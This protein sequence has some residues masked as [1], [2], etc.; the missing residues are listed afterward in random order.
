MVRDQASAATTL[1]RI[2]NEP[3]AFGAIKGKTGILASKANSQDRE[4]ALR[5][6]PALARNLERFLEMRRETEHKHQTE[7]RAARLRV[8]IDIPALSPSAK[9]VL[10]RVRDAIDRNDLSDGLAY[11]LADRMVKDELESFAKAVAER[12][13]ERTFLG[14][15]AKDVSGEAFRSITAG[16]NPAQKAEVQTAWISM[17]TVQKL[18]AH[19]RTVAAMKQAE[20]LSQT[21]TQRF[22][23]T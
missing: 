1:F 11:A 18:S 21:R 4:I 19:K 9:T 8:S 20:S 16:M 6:V 22:S 5:N 15:A 10:E 12:F 14:V 17:R 3:E 7:E 2:A 23:L 13:G